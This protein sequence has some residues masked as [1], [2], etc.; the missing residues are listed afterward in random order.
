[1]TP[2]EGELAGREL[3]LARDSLEETLLLLD[4]GAG[5]GG[6]SRMYYGVFHAVRAALLVRGK[7]A[8]THSGQIGLFATTFGEAPILG[9]LL[10]LRAQADYGRE[11]L[12][13]SPEQL[14]AFLAEAEAL[15]D[16]CGEIVE[17]ALALG[18]DEADPPPDS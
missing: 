5:R 4:A 6:A 9:R 12:S 13:A 10:E 2:G 16:R 1:M 17:E 11:E 18:P 15:V 8:K 3:T 7:H 14:R